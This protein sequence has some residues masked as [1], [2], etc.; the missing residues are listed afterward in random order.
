MVLVAQAIAN[1]H[2]IPAQGTI[3][4]GYVEDEISGLCQDV[5][6]DYLVLSQ[7]HGHGDTDVSTPDR[8]AR[9]RARIEKEEGVEVVIA[10][11]GP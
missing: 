11:D 9:F 3:R 6:A 4:H 5:D 2:G 10:G 7:F 1:S 8:L